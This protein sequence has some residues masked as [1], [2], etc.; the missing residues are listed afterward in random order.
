MF[1]RLQKKQC[2]FVCLME[3][4]VIEM[5]LDSSMLTMWNN[6]FC[7]FFIWNIMCNNYII[8]ISKANEMLYFN[9]YDMASVWFVTCVFFVEENAAK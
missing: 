8:C 4:K 5:D 3:V 9:I 1:L 2:N 6:W 7:F